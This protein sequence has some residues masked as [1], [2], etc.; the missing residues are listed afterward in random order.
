MIARLIALETRIVGRDA[1][2][3][4]HLCRESAHSRLAHV[5]L[6]SGFAR[7]NM[8]FHFFCILLFECRH[9]LLG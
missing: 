8:R 7:I 9:L 6:G 3:R 2:P 5:V 1:P 4:L